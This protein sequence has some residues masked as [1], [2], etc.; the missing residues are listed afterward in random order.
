VIWASALLVIL[1][2]ALQYSICG[3]LNCF[4]NCSGLAVLLTSSYASDLDGVRICCNDDD[5]AVPPLS[6]TDACQ[7]IKVST[8]TLLLCLHSTENC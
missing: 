5:L 1:I 2:N 6:G 7:Q 4:Q 8:Y 3:I